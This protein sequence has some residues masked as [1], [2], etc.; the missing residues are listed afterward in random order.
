MLI[1]SHERKVVM[2]ETQG[3]FWLASYPKS[4]NTWFRIV[5]SKLL[6]PAS[7]LTVIN[8]MDSI[9]GSPMVANRGWMNKALGFDSA[10]L[11]DDDVDKL[12][13]KTYASYAATL[14]RPVYIKVHD[15]YT[16][17]DEHQPLF[18]NEGCLGAIYFIRNPLDVAIS[19]AHHVQCPLDWS[20]HMMEQPGFEVPLPGQRDKQ[21]RQKLLSWS[22]HVESWTLLPDFPVLVLRYE[23][24]LMDPVT[25]FSKALHFLNLH[26][27]LEEITQAI[28]DSSFEKLQ[29]FERQFGFKEK[30][31]GSF[32]R[33][34]IAGDW[35]NTLTETQA[36]QLVK[37]HAAIMQQYGYLD[38]QGRL[39]AGPATTAKIVDPA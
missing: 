7:H 2:P 8:E 34:G 31:N 13:P 19:L 14:K 37:Q 12:R 22:L 30:Q 25:S 15:A 26:F 16:F 24:M 33:K 20:I 11:N 5:L 6:K 1:H 29:D 4:G 39:P 23:D 32:F 3:I 36:H 28:E 17:I 21:L 27:T 9:L 18:P 35:L 38:A 10:A